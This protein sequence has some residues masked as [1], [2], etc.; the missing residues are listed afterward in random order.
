MK[1]KVLASFL[2]LM[3]VFSMLPTSAFAA[4]TECAHEHTEEE[5]REATCTTPQR[6]VLYCH[7]CEQDIK[8]LQD[9]LS[10]ALGHD[11]VVDETLPGYKAATCTEGGLDTRK[12]SRCDVTDSVESAP[13][14]HKWSEKEVIKEADCVNPAGVERTCERCG[15]TERVP[16]EGELAEPAL[17]HVFE[18]K[19]V[20]PTCKD[21]GYTLH[22]C[23]RCGYSYKDAVVPADSSAH[24]P[25]VGKVL[26]PATCTAEGIAHYVCEVCGVSLG[27][28]TIPAD[29]VWEESGREDATCGK[30][31]KVTYLCSVC[32]ETKEETV[33][34][35]G[36]HT[37]EEKTVDATCTEPAKVGKVCSVCGEEGE[38][39]IVEGSKPTGHKLVL[40]TD[41]EN[42][43]AATCEEGGL[44]TFKCENCDYTEEKPTEALGHK[45]NEGED[46]AADCVNPAGAKYTC[47]VC[48]ATKVDPYEGELAK[49]AEGH[50]YEKVVTPAT[51]K[52]GGYTTY[53]CSVC[54]DSY[55]DDE[56]PVDENA[57][58][59][60]IAKVL[61]DATCTTKGIAKYTCAIC[62]KDL[63]YK[64]TETSHDWKEVERTDATCG[65]DGKVS[66]VCTKCEDTKEETI[67]AT[68][69]HELEEVF[70]DATCTEPA[71]VGKACKNCDYTEEM[72][73]VEGSEALGHDFVLD[74]ENEN[75][76]AATCEEGGLDTFKCSRCEETKEEPT[77]A[78]GHKWDDGVHQD[79]TC[80]NA[81]GVL[82]TCEIC[83]KTYVEAYPDGI[84]EPALGHKYE[85]V[86]TPATCKEGG[87][88]TYTCSVCGDSYK[89]DETPVDENAH[90]AKIA[91]VLKD[92][93]CTTKGIAKY[94]CAICGKDLGYKTTETSHDWKEVERTDA[95]CGKDGKVSYVCTKCE[96]TKEETI[97]ATGE[98][99]LEEVFRDATC[100]EPA[101]VGKACKNCDYTEEMEPVEGSEALGHDFVLD[102]ENENYKAATCE[103]GGLDTFKCSRCEETK[104]EPTEALGHK[105]DEENAVNVPADCLHDEHMLVKCA[106]CNETK[107]VAYPDGVGEKALGHDYVETVVEATCSAK[108]YTLHVCSRCE[109]SFTDNVTEINPENHVWK[110]TSIKDATCSATGVEKRVCEACGKITYAVSE[111]L[112]HTF[113]E[114]AE[115]VTKEPTC[116][117]AG[118]ISNT[119]TVC[120]E[121][122]VVAAV[123]ATGEHTPVE[124]PATDT[125][126]AGLKCSVCGKILREP[127]EKG[128]CEHAN[129]V[130]IPAVDATC[131]STGLTA[132]LECADCGALLV[133]QE[134]TEKLAHTEEVIPAVAATCS[135]TGLTEGKKCSVCGEVLVA[136]EQTEKLAHTEEV[137]PAVAA[138]CSANGLTE[139]KK[140][141][142]CG[143]VLVAQ[144]QT[145]KLAHTPV[146][147]ADVAPGCTTA[148]SHGG[149]KCSVCGAILSAPEVVA[150]AGHQY[151]DAFYGSDEQGS[152]V[153]WKCTVCG[154]ETKTYLS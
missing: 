123:P 7:D 25:V 64:T 76:K 67:P 118:E 62:G 95:T 24:T 28:K 78:L 110:A 38:M 29:H 18:E 11:M 27:Y 32:G 6:V 93:T 111:K 102:T 68:G 52:E 112:P 70:R 134:Q 101:M 48:G 79:A 40:D 126:T 113:D 42:Y 9:D 77:E 145:E 131:T 65:K 94:T 46:Q 150:P 80:E 22:E 135:A 15:E 34:A 4:E 71:M 120:G 153:G 140:C 84:A 50:K 99:E 152:Y 16:F 116:A 14:G 149:E 128:S 108:G 139:G 2:A 41:N 105:W 92:A 5:V 17:G 66:Y 144:E 58:E 51:C 129:T 86:V 55:K 3:M 96:D 33:P 53:T 47:T 31:G 115:I 45:W 56:T 97:P 83:Q 141:S 63:G 109:D 23:S 121:T 104:E 59:A 117:D 44:D 138:T 21:E 146:A 130:V 88:T 10:P 143:E 19:V 30:D 36:E 107:E 85:K 125:M 89:D 147:I 124:I 137:I 136:Q 20:A 142:V 37:W 60:K 133:P 148:G 12:C 100:T 103:E 8:I 35:T 54:G 106:N 87:Y 73:P 154:H 119:C 132:G 13:L 91:K 57:H 43:K 122:V 151:G 114:E 90:E 39:E 61:K 75:Y 81:S 49:P 74:T 26:R 72:E 98:H 127:V 1:R 82:H 69:E